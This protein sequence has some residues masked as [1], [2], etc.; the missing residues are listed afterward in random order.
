LIGGGDFNKSEAPSL[1]SCTE[2]LNTKSIAFDIMKK[3]KLRLPRH[4]HS[5]TCLKDKFLIV[6]GSR[7]EKDEAHKSVEQYNVDMD[8]WFDLPSLNHGRYYHSSCVLAD[9]WIYVFAG[10]ANATKKY[11]NSIERLDVNAQGPSKVWEMIDLPIESF[12]VRQGP[13]STQISATE[14][15]IFGGFGGDYLKDVYVLKHNDKTIEKIS[16][17]IVKVFG[18]QM[19]TMFDSNSRCVISADWQSKK[20]VMFKVADRSWHLMRE[21]Q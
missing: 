5:I 9:R 4:G 14:I 17:S 21:L 1:T 3:D 16:D 2:I 20:T 19:P 13:G 8:V 6:T 18:Y 10:I 12:P 7:I 11:F 15:L